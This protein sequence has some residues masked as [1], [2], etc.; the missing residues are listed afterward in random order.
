M[1]EQAS[2][3]RPPRKQSVWKLRIAVPVGR[4]FAEWLAASWRLTEHNVEG[5][6]R[7]RAEKKPYILAVWHG[8]LLCA[9]MANRHRDYAAMA[10]SHG[11]AEIIARMMLRW[12]YRFVRGS[13]SKGGKEA[14][15]GMVEMLQGG[16]HFA[17][18]PDGPRGPRGVPKAGTVVAAL[19]AGVPIVTVRA[20][21]S[22]AWRFNSWDRFC[23]AK[24][25][26][27]VR[28]IYGDPWMPTA[29]DEHALREFARRLG[30]PEAVTLDAGPNADGRA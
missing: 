18:T 6:Q 26:A 30:P 29:T 11:D 7:L 21:V 14:L 9:A 15:A 3:A 13:S 5:W 20:E 22:R 12:G 19:R 25:F 16:Q 17:I 27:R 10:S 1:T 24:P 4:I 23:V 8:Q 28:L 2:R